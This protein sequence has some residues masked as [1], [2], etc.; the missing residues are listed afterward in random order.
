MSGKVSFKVIRF[1]IKLRSLFLL[2]IMLCF[3]LLSSQ[4]SEKLF[5]NQIP[6]AF[7]KVE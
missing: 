7:S 3:R 4:K 6:Q 2:I 5:E 1:R